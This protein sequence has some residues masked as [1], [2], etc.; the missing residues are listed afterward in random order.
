[1]ALDLQT[2]I[3]AALE[4]S[5]SIA[6]GRWYMR[7]GRLCAVTS[8]SA[9]LVRWTFDDGSAAEG[10]PAEFKARALDEIAFPPDRGSNYL[11]AAWQIAS[12]RDVAAPVRISVLGAT[13]QRAPTDEDRLTV[14]RW[15]LA[16]GQRREPKREE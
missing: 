7:G 12:A 11:D 4:Q 13:L 2:E 9:E 15:V 3:G 10:T 6:A 8:A 5:A 14:S 16:L 1:M